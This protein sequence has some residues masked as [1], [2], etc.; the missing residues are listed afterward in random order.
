MRGVRTCAVA[1]RLRGAPAPRSDKG[2]GATG[3]ADG[4]NQPD[5]HSARWMGSRCAECGKPSQTLY[6]GNGCKQRAWRRRHAPGAFTQ[7]QLDASAEDARNVACLERLWRLSRNGDQAALHAALAEAPPL[8][9]GRFLKDRAAGR[10]A[11]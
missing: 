10:I 3:N 9:R 11:S 2:P 5:V 4:Q 8:L 6:C 1:E 7:A